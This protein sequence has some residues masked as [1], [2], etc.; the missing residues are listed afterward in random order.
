[1]ISY[2]ICLSIWRKSLSVTTFRA[3]HGFCLD[4]F[5]TKERVEYICRPCTRSR[6]RGAHENIA[7]MGSRV[8]QSLCSRERRTDVTE[9]TGAGTGLKEDQR[10]FSASE[11]WKKEWNQTLMFV[12]QKARSW[13]LFLI[14]SISLCNRNKVISGGD[15]EAGEGLGWPLRKRRTLCM[16][17]VR[18]G[19]SSG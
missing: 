11:I 4:L 7:E 5:L 6:E 2:D 10:T 15:L 19:E 13:R 9:V 14:A 3:I 12:T 16:A 1:M 18:T 17:I 8:E